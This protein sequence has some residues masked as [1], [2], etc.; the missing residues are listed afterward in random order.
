MPEEVIKAC[1]KSGSESIAYTYSEPTTFYE[2][3][4]DTAKLARE[5]KIRSLLKSNGFINEKPLHYL[6][7]VIDA[8]NIDLKIFDEAIYEKL[9]SGKLA[10]VL[11]A[12][13]IF[14]EEGVW[15]EI[16]NLII[17]TWTD[18]YDTIKRM[19][20]WLCTNGLSDTPL[21]FSRFTPLYKL[22]QLPTTPIDMLTKAYLIAKESGMKFV[23]L[24]NA[25]G[26]QAE[27]TYCPKC[28]KILIER[29]VFTILNN[30]IVKGKCKFCGEKIPG[31]WS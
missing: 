22:N 12:L 27:N 15:L 8:A 24:G 7:K 3:T 13:K 14:R 4:Y 11:K 29:R 19:C 17:P 5:Q 28:R 10:P 26:H 30:H 16:T 20:E 6:C 25:A 18:N 31:V 9:S 2:Y 21:H 1:I 23:Y